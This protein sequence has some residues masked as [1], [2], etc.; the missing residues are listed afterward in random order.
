MITIQLRLTFSC[1]T[2]RCD[3]D[4]PRRIITFLGNLGIDEL[5]VT[6]SG[7]DFDARLSRWTVTVLDEHEQPPTE[8]YA[9]R[10]AE[11]QLRH[12]AAAIYMPPTEYTDSEQ[13][14]ISV[15]VWLPQYAFE[16]VWYSASRLGSEHTAATLALTAPFRGSALIY[17]GGNPDDN[18]KLWKAE[19]ENPLL[20]EATD[21]CFAPQR[22][23]K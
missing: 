8:F 13:P 19:H 4:G 17:S 7:R 12:L 9:E 22:G 5:A 21:F 18:E 1:Q 6:R 16:S 15:Y 14:H 23:P 11:R 3:A 10:A 20:L 2:V